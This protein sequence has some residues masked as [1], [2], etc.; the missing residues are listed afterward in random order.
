M[1]QCTKCG[2]LLDE[3]YFSPRKPRPSGT[4]KDGL[5][6]HCKMCRPKKNWKRKYKALEERELIKIRETDKHYF[7]ENGVCYI[8]LKIGFR[9]CKGK[10]ISSSQKQMS[11]EKLRNYYFEGI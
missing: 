2:Q 5:D 11:I 3:K 6:Y 10:F 7:T 8:K 1:K 4:Y 9:R